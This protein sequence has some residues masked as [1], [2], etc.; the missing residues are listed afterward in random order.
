MPGSANP[1]TGVGCRSPGG[2]S[3]NVCPSSFRL[4]KGLYGSKDVKMLFGALPSTGVYKKELFQ[5]GCE[6]L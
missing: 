5:G 1:V 6:D 3:D 2:G 4:F